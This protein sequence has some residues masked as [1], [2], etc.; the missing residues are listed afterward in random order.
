MKYAVGFDENMSNADE[1]FLFVFIAI[2]R[3]CGFILFV[4]QEQS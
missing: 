2:R 1:F 4:R 3:K